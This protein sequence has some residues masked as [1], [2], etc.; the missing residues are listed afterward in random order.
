MHNAD[1]ALNSSMRM[2]MVIN[3]KHKISIAEIFIGTK[4]EKLKF[5]LRI[6]VE[7]K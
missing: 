2:V 6:S 4:K 5:I 3:K 1:V 7:I